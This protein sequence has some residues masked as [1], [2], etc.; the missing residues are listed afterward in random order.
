MTD[1]IRVAIIGA[2]GISRMHIQ[3]YLDTGR[4]EVVALADLEPAAMREKNEQFGIEPAHYTD[5]R[6]MMAEVRPDV[7]SICTWQAGHPEWTIAAA[8]YRPQAILCE[9]P[10]A[11]SVGG[12]ERMLVACRRNGVKLAIGHQRRF[13][14]A[15]ELARHMIREGRIGAVHLIQSCGGSGLPN[16][17][18]HQMDMY[19]F[20]LN[21]DECEWVMGNIERRTDQYE[22]NTRIEDRA[23]GTFRFRSGAQALILSDLLPSYYQGARIYGTEGMIDLTT[24]DL[25]LLNRD[26]KGEW[27]RHVPDGR[28]YTLAEQGS[29]FEWL[30]G[31][32]AQA[33][34]VADWVEGAASY[35]STG[36]DG[37]K[38]LQMVHA[39]YESA[40]MHE[41]VQL[42]LQTRVNPLDLMVESGHLAP[43][44]PGRYDIRAGQL[45][46]ERMISDREKRQF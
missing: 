9:K 10:M 2:G 30:E 8:A 33:D 27:E 35:R 41:K 24:E 42:P 36:E 16:F 37:Y 14:P 7:V 4:Y 21:D 38:A 26:T 1:R 39:V 45:R 32:A 40:R 34:G 6:A 25:K 17:A 15:Y 23:M 12:A 20:L 22:R 46:G 28:F 43:E 29:R 31:A 5:A 3:G 44:R 11:D 19:R 18:S 13:L